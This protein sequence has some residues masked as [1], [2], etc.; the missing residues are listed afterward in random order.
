M[1][2]Y[3]AI[4]LGIIVLH[5]LHG[6]SLQG[7]T[8]E[9][10]FYGVKTTFIT[11]TACLFTYEEQQPLYIAFQLLMYLKLDS[12]RNFMS[13]EISTEIP[14]E[15]LS[16]QGSRG[17]PEKVVMDA[18]KT[19]FCAVIKY[20]NS[21]VKKYILVVYSTILMCSGCYTLEMLLYANYPRLCS[22][23]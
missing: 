17:F 13:T 18:E 11:A 2:V 20:G 15:S 5:L 12:G 4:R 22:D 6:G 1:E 9:W 14:V 21:S 23:I 8:E 7:N 3:E 10:R 16:K 19:I